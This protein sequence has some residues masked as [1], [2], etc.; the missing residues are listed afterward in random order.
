MTKFGFF[1]KERYQ[2]YRCKQCGKTMSWIPERPLDDLRVP[3]EK[4]VQVLNLL[5]EGVGIRACERLTGVNKNT[6][7]AILETAGRKCARLLNS[8]IKDLSVEFVQVDEIWSFVHS[9]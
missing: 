2:R 9:K 1:G 7:L 3:Q 8:K 6:V 4:A 5:V